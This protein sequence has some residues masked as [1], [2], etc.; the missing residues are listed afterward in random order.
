LPKHDLILIEVDY[1][2]GGRWLLV[3]AEDGE[4]S[5]IVAPPH[6]SPSERWLVAVA[7]SVGPSGPPNGIDIIPATRDPAIKAWHYR[8]P[9]DGQWLYEFAGW[10]GDDSVKLLATSLDPERH[11][12]ASVEHQDGTWH[13]NEPK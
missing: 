13:I 6:Y 5:E 7:S 4:S 12:A 11:V 1:W 2:E 10:D 8:V 3:R 9:D